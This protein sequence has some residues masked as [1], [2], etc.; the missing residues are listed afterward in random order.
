[1]QYS[2]GYVYKWSHESVELFDTNKKL[3]VSD[4]AS[5]DRTL[6]ML[7]MLIYTRNMTQENCFSSDV[8]DWRA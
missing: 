1:M 4:A 6:A 3:I 7:R 2:P 8:Y 5:V